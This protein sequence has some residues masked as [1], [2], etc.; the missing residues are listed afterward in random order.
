MDWMQAFNNPALS[1]FTITMA[2]LGEADNIVFYAVM[3]VT[4]IDHASFQGA[5]GQ[6]G[7]KSFATV[8]CRAWRRQVRR[9]PGPAMIEDFRHVCDRF[10]CSVARS[11]KIVALPHRIPG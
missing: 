10:D 11:T 4:Q 8:C 1:L 7:F 3:P 9:R 2:T 6:V 5:A